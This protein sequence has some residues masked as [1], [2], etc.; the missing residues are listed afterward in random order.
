MLYYVEYRDTML[1]GS[2][3]RQVL[4]EVR[5]HKIVELIWQQKSVRISDL[6][7]LFDV[8]GETIRRDLRK[9]ESDNIL[10][11]THGGAVVND[12]AHVVPAF[13][14][15][16]ERNLLEKRRIA[17]VAARLAP[18]NGTVMLDSGSTT[19]EIARQLVDRPI[20]VLTND[21][22]IALEI[23]ASPHAA[24]V[25]LG[26]MQQKGGYSLTGP[27]CVE[28]IKRYNVDVV[29]LGVGGLA[30]KKGVTTASS[31]EAEVKRAMM[32]AAKD[33]YCV[34]DASKLGKAALVSYAEPKEVRAIITNAAPEDPLV[35]DWR[36]S[37][38]GFI[39]A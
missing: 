12:E 29:F 31:A 3:E 36:E 10:K 9:L 32:E 19:L 13:E 18:D 8:S 2:E 24:L 34:A 26:G 1:L 39:F 20:T 15:R 22:T 23:S 38:V 11:R 35:R 21:L 27:E 28:R 25:V 4:G 6:Q 33:I 7:D 17:A 37:G 30:L 14:F 16:S 5:Q